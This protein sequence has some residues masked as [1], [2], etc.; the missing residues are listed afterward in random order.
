MKMPTAFNS[1]ETPTIERSLLQHSDY[2]VSLSRNDRVFWEGFVPLLLSNRCFTALGSDNTGDEGSTL[3][4]LSLD[5]ILRANNDSDPANTMIPELDEL[6]TCLGPC[7]KH[8][9]SRSQPIPFG[10]YEQA[11]QLN[12]QKELSF[13]VLMKNSKIC[14]AKVDRMGSCS[15]ILTTYFHKTVSLLEHRHVQQQQSQQ[16]HHNPHF[17]PV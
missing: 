7:A 5:K 9:A 4:D 1:G 16:P 2:F 15:L 6:L 3:I 12:K 13:T 10:W 11:R 14:I 8:E 17:S